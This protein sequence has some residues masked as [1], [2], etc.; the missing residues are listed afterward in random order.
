MTDRELFCTILSNGPLMN[1]DAVVVLAGEDAEPRL[2]VALQLMLSRAA[3]TVVL[4]GGKHDPPRWIGA[5]ALRGQLLGMGLAHD[6]IVVEGDSQNTREQAVNVV[7]IIAA[8]GWAQILLVV[9]SYH[10]YRAYLTFLR[11]LQEAGLDDKV[12][13]VP[14]P[15]SQTPWTEAP[16]GVEQTRA[17]LLAVE[18][19]KVE[20]YGEHV[21]SY[22]EG[23]AY[24]QRWEREM[25]A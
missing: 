18:F 2:Q 22:A 11:A 6:R 20:E 21:A 16:E 14:V 25:A 23:L 12:R 3:N 17:D 8:E 13:L 1:A 9:S 4:S 15:A 5:D 24:L 19:A 7:E 10:M